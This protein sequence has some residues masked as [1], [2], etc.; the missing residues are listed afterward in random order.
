[1]V[2]SPKRIWPVLNT[3]CWRLDLADIGAAVEKGLEKPLESAV[4]GLSGLLRSVL[5][6]VLGRLA[7]CEVLKPFL[8]ETR[9][10]LDPLSK[11]HSDLRKGTDSRPLSLISGFDTRFL[12]DLAVAT[13]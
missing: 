7:N 3:F 2:A 12:F 8:E 11:F 4:L 6:P 10:A 9:E 1:M 5:N 13:E